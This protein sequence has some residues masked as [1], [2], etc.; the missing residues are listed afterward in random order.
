[1]LSVEELGNAFQASRRVSQIRLKGQWLR[2]AGFQPGQ[3]VIVR[4]EGPGQ[5]SIAL[6]EK[7]P[8]EKEF[9]LVCQ[10][11]DHALAALK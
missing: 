8:I 5:L 7:T 4:I 10:R 3:R 1:M 2:A 6:P 11:L 9:S